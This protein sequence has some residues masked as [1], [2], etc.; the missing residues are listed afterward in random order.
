MTSP[1]SLFAL[2]FL[3]TAV[4]APAAAQESA[5]GRFISATHSRVNRL[6]ERSPRNAGAEARR[7]REISEILS[8]LLDLQELSRRAL[9]DEWDRRTA[10]EREEFVAI[11]SRLVHRSYQSG[12]ER[13]LRYRVDVVGEERDS[14]EAVVQTSA[15]NRE[16]RREPPIRIDYRVQISDGVHKVVDVI[17]DG[18]SM[19]RNYR[20]QFRRIIRREGWDGLMRRMRERG[21]E[22][23]SSD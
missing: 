1:Y 10:P 21:A 12:L 3:L 22:P 19:V 23:S 7:D 9:A 20:R 15:Q 4:V 16:N 8:E 5:E 17:T 13:T 6:L 11:L 14:G 2:T 18:V